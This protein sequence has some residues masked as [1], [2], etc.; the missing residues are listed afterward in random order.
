MNSM[1]LLWR[2]QSCILQND[3][4]PRF[5]CIIYD[6]ETLL[7]S[8]GKGDQYLKIITFH[9]MTHILIFNGY[10]LDNLG[11]L[12]YDEK[13]EIYKI[14][15]PK[16]LSMAK[17]HFNCNSL[18]GIPLEN[19][20]GE[21]SY[22]SHW[23]ATYM[24]GDYMVSYRNDDA[25]LSD[26]TLALF[27]DAE[28]Y[29]V[30]YYSGGLFK[31]GKN[32]GCK[33]FENN[34]LSFPDEYCNSNIKEQ[35][36]TT[37]RGSK[38]ICSENEIFNECRVYSFL[39]SCSSDEEPEEDGEYFGSDS[40][41]LMSSLTPNTYSGSNDIHPVCYKIKCD[42]INKQ[43]IIDY[44]DSLSI[45]C[46]EKELIENPQGFTGKINCPNYYDICDS[47]SLC[48]NIFNCLDQKSKTLEESYDY[49][50][51]NQEEK[52]DKIEP[53]IDE[54][55]TSNQIFTVKGIKNSL[56][57]CF[58]VT[59]SYDIDIEGEFSKEVN[60]L[61]KV[62]MNLTT[63]SGKKIK[64]MCTPFDKTS[65]STSYLQCSIDICKYPLENVD[66]YLPT[67]APKQA[68]Y[69]IKNWENTIG[70]EPGVSNKINGVSCLPEIKNTFIPSSIEGI[71]CEKNYYKFKISGNWENN[72]EA[73]LPNLLLDI[74]LI[75]N[76]EN[77]D[78]ITCD[79]NDKSNSINFIC[80]FDGVGNI[81]IKEQYFEGFFEAFTFKD[82][83][84]SIQAESC[85]INSNDE[86][87]SSYITLSFI[88]IIMN[89]F[90]F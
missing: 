23:E 68:G 82:I 19:Q 39:Q 49:N 36:C 53:D 58:T 63:S 16:A 12:N 22:G 74:E 9:E 66:I 59:N 35:E 86:N 5:G 89:L 87:K 79:Y 27:D 1:G 73:S 76:N 67:E 52:T 44:S 84:S 48:N 47:T 33:F 85:K 61:S 21:G 32:K 3:K 20:G 29:Q 70:K 4:I 77:E 28:F 24:F 8:N 83:P 81:D 57:S 71:G 17:K 2:N 11:F 54:S 38:G 65:F 34:C 88:L 60:I 80:E 30:E 18:D 40:F 14:I 26:I 10:I 42:N 7:L 31:F 25:Q 41:C 45:I 51:G 55:N 69:L 6:K 90:F 56:I 43:I 72:D 37:S 15:S 78:E 50:N 64:A 62:Y 46:K 75:L 13:K